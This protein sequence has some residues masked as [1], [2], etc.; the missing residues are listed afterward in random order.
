MKSSESP[1]EQ[2]EEK[3]PDSNF[4]PGDDDLSGKTVDQNSTAAEQT[5]VTTEEKLPDEPLTDEER[6]LLYEKGIK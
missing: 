5:N 2:D 1:K 3:R 4:N 6:H